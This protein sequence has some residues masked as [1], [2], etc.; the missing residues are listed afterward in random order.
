MP[1]F[2]DC[3]LRVYISVYNVVALSVRFSMLYKFLAF[4]M[5]R[6][7]I[8]TDFFNQ[9]KFLYK[10][11][12][13]EFSYLFWALLLIFG[14]VVYMSLNYESILY[15]VFAARASAGMILTQAP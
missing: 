3:M 7:F 4:Y 9:L 5:R 12:N 10:E 2:N 1:D 14:W 15:L 13:N 11:Q 8:K 6:Y